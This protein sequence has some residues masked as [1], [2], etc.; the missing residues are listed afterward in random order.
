VLTAI[1][2][3]GISACV[4]QDT[5]IQHYTTKEGLPS[6]NCYSIFQDSNQFIWIATDAGVSRFDGQ[7]FENFTIDDG[8]PDNQVLQIKEDNKGRI[9]FLAFNGE[10]SYFHNGK[11]Y[12][13][14]NDETLRLLGFGLALTRTYCFCSMA[15]LCQNT[16]PQINKTSLFLVTRTKML[17]AGYGYIAKIACVYLRKVNLIW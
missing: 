5:F 11:I 8:M 12:N 3:G 4:A 17:M 7:R 9:W 15:K 2:T 10:M 6:N 14:T 16:A 13:S 1:L